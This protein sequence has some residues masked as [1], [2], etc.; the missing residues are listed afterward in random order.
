MTPEYTVFYAN[1][2]Y[3]EGSK[4]R[5]SQE[6]PDGAYCRNYVGHWFHVRNLEWLRIDFCDLP[7][8]MQAIALIY[9]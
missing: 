6:I 5:F 2:L 7:P 9:F 8:E 3:G 1:K 4:I